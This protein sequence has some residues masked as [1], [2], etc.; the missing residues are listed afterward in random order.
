[1]Q[2]LSKEEKNGKNPDF[3]LFKGRSYA[4]ITS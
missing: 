4:D 1:M 2:R 3:K